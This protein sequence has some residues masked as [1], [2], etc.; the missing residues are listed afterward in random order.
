[1]HAYGYRRSLDWLVLGL[2]VVLAFFVN[3]GVG[4]I[5]LETCY[6]AAWRTGS[7]KK[8]KGKKKSSHGCHGYPLSL[9]P[10]PLPPSV[11]STL[12]YL[13]GRGR[14]KRQGRRPDAAVNVALRSPKKSTHL[15]YFYEFERRR[16]GRNT[17]SAN[18]L[19]PR[20][21]LSDGGGVLRAPER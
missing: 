13:S 5:G 2:F 1:M 12:V 20:G 15:D 11:A 10:S 8:R 18:S 14:R 17:P 19:A 7:L 4:D 3:K 21:V 9:P 16:D 6:C